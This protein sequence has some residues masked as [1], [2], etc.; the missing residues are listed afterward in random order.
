MG[1]YASSVNQSTTNYQNT[2]ISQSDVTNPLNFLNSA[3]NKIGSNESVS[4][5]SVGAGSTLSFLDGGAITKAFDFGTLAISKIA[6]LSTQYN[7]QVAEASTQAVDAV[8]GSTSTLNSSLV[9]SASGFD[10]TKNRN[11]LIAA[12]AV[13]VAYMAFKGR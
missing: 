7:K 12:V 13:A 5:T 2:P 11:L 6:D 8:V 3:G 10:W 1:S 9:E 4:N